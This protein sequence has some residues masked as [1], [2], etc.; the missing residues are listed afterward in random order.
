MIS[1]RQQLGILEDKSSGELEKIA[2]LALF[3]QIAGMVVEDA[4]STYVGWSVW[5][6]N[7]AALIPDILERLSLR[8]SEPPK[9]VSATYPGEIFEKFSVTEKRVDVYA[10][11]Y[12]SEVTKA[13]DFDLPASFGINWKR[14][15]SV[16]LVAKDELPMWNSLGPYMRECIN[17]LMNA[18]G[19]LLAMCNNKIKHGPQVLVASIAEAGIS[20]G[21]NLD[22]VTDAATLKTIRLLPNGSR[23]QETDDE[24]SNHI[25][26]APFL[27]MDAANMRRWFF[28]HIVHTANSMYIHGTWL[29]NT[30]FQDEKRPLSKIPNEAMRIIKEQG[31]HLNRTFGINVRTTAQNG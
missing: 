1:A 24:F 19:A 2:A 10:R 16:K 4:L 15:P 5:S 20:R 12:L 22:Q 13:S 25:R 11:A 7:K 14:N 9:A 21:F 31:P 3:Y 26:A 18:K 6:K 30:N 27:L 23:V 8:L 28:Q 29:Y 17:P